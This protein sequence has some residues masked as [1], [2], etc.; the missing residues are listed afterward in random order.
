MKIN[1][2]RTLWW[3]ILVFYMV[4]MLLTAGIT[5]HVHTTQ[6][7]MR[8]E[9]DTLREMDMTNAIIVKN[10]Q[11]KLGVNMSL[12]QVSGELEKYYW[13]GGPGHGGPCG[14]GGHRRKPGEK[15]KPGESWE[16]GPGPGDSN[17]RPVG[18]GWHHPQIVDLE[19]KIVSTGKEPEKSGFFPELDDFKLSADVISQLKSG[20]TVIGT[21]KDS[22]KRGKMLFLVRPLRI[23]NKVEGGIL[24]FM[25]GGFPPQ[26]LEEVSI[27]LLQSILI[28][29][30]ITSLI[31][32]FFARSL[33]R[34]VEEME[35]AA[36]RLAH[37]DFSS[38]IKSKRQDE[39]GVLADAFDDMTTKIENNLKSRTRMMLDISHELSTPLTII[40][41]TV[42]AL[43]DGIIESDE[44]KKRHLQ[45]ILIQI[46]QLSYLLNDVTD[47]S[48]FETGEIKLDLGEFLINEPLRGLIEASGIV[49]R[50]KDIT[51]TWETEGSAIKVAG[52]QRR[53]MQI[54]RNLINNAIVHNPP[55][56]TIGVAVREEG[57]SVRFSVEDDGA[58]I[59]SEELDYIFERFYKVDKSR[60]SDASGAG[61]GLAIVKEI[62]AVHGSTIAV[63]LLPK[64]K[65]FY[66]SLP[67]ARA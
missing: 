9:K 42:E 33:T 56:T 14:P 22:E 19:G 45:S 40:H 36:N 65:V 64:G 41:G 66:F 55:G 16:F 60:K 49:A 32:F 25:P 43:L 62:L 51:L 53:I 50:K 48:K 30:C 63:T 20:K 6:M 4:T 23:N 21:V 17:H 7:R 44:D 37:G 59:P 8:I 1:F 57:D 5:Y 35:A 12:E 11:E 3:K 29:I 13:P 58:A 2:F 10:I 38:R 28:A 47:L 27:S 18:P 46:Q 24:C 31:A 26:M 67:A 34:P 61:L 54:M 39:L 52:D 15:G